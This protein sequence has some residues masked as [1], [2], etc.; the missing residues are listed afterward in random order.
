MAHSAF[1]ALV[2]LQSSL[3]Q[4][5]LYS[6]LRAPAADDYT[7]ACIVSG[8]FYHTSLSTQDYTI[9]MPTNITGPGKDPSIH[10]HIQQC[11]NVYKTVLLKALVDLDPKSFFALADL[12]M[13]ASKARTIANRPLGDH[14]HH[15]LIIIGS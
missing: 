4:P 2:I 8:L 3:S 13:I 1:F 5:C 6:D 11:R 10:Q 12:A 7:P 15:F 9:S 14:L